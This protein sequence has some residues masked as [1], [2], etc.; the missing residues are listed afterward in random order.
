MFIINVFD[1]SI[2]ISFIIMRS[3]LKEAQINRINKLNGLLG[4]PIPIDILSRVIR[5]Y[6]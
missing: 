1:G 6:H 4:W 3:F 5:A 2:I